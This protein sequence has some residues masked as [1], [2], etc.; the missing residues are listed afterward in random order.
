MKRGKPFRGILLFLLWG[1]IAIHEGGKTGGYS[2]EGAMR[3]NLT[4][5]QY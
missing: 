5:M 2:F 1:W 3:I 4:K